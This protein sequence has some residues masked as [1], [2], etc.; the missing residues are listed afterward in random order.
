MGKDLVTPDY[1]TGC[2]QRVVFSGGEFAQWRNAKLLPRE[3]GR[4]PAG[5]EGAI[6]RT[7]HSL[8]KEPVLHHDYVF[9][10]ELVRLGSLTA[11]P[12][13][14]TRSALWIPSRLNW[15]LV[16]LRMAESISLPST[17]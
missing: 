7:L 9:K 8:F 16:L 13:L 6:S 14:N 3:R 15:A 11:T 5:T 1:E 4:C 17:T 2:V 12:P 10:A